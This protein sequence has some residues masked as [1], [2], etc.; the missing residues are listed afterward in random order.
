MESANQQ[1]QQPILGGFV[2]LS[3]L[4]DGAAKS[5]LFPSESSARWF[6]QMNRQALVEAEAIAYHRRRVMVHPER[7]ETVARAVALS[8]ARKRAAR[9]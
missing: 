4:W 5:A 7:M 6:V 3:T 8:C 1:T 2:P 9:T